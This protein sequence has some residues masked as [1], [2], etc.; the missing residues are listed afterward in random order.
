VMNTLIK[1]HLGR[2]SL[3]MKQHA[4]KGRS[5]RAF[6]V[7]DVFFFEIPT[8]YPIFFDAKSTPEVVLQVFLTLSDCLEWVLWHTNLI[9]LQLSVCIRCFMYPN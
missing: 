5:E 2:A 6:E 4:D 3:R 7:G 8:I 9:C 1:Q